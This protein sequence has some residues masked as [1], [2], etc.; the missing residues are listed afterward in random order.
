MGTGEKQAVVGGRPSQTYTR[1]HR[2]SHGQKQ[3][4][5]A[6]FLHTGLRHYH[7]GRQ[8]K[9]G[10]TGTSLVSSGKDST[11]PMQEVQVRSPVRELDPT[12][13]N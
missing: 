13:H 11:L 5:Q 4:E 9:E 3:R 10:C 6:R 8:L 12:C 1:S 2:G 7:P